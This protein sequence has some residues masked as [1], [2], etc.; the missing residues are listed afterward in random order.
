MTREL[1]DG[2]D[3]WW[4]QTPPYSGNGIRRAFNILCFVF[5]LFR[6]ARDL[7]GVVNPDVVIAS[8]T[9]PIDI[10]PAAW[11]AARCNARLIFELH[12]LWP[13]SPMQLGKMSR[14]NPF[15]MLMQ[16]GE[17]FACRRADR[18]VSILPL[19]DRYLIGR[20]MDP[21]KFV[22]VP[23]GIVLDD[24][25]QSVSPVLPPEPRERL[26]NLKNKGTFV[27]LYAGAH[28]PANNLDVV[29]NAAKNLRGEQVSICLFGDG[30]EKPRMLER[31]NADDLSFVEFFDPVPKGTVPQ[32]LACA[33]A[34]L[35][36]LSPS[37]LFSFGISP[38]KLIDYMMAGRPIIAA[39]TAGN[40]PVEEHRCG[41]TVA[42]DDARGVADC[43]RRLMRMSF[44]ERQAM[45]D[46]GR[47]AATEH[48]SYEVLARRF[49]AC[50][51]S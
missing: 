13:L 10:F 12:D 24:W 37:P 14:W 9:Y 2:I 5:Q 29:L 25:T 15:I 39:L 23:N 41:L 11:I 40:N 31:R 26:R 17:D 45:G 4:L 18:V 36:T 27:V 51:V 38:N 21:S 49:A 34:L 20:G 32:L 19:A 6:F 35:F 8:S 30:S 28:G 7:A 1:I 50:F 16:V 43:V 42:A 47:S 46:A 3:Y 22:H 33:D 44:G 48:Y